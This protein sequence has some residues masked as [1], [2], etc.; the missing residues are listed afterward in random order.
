MIYG[1][2]GAWR[3]Q[4]E[5]LGQRERAVAARRADYNGYCVLGD[6]GAPTLAMVTPPVAIQKGTRVLISRWD[7]VRAGTRYPPEGW[8]RSVGHTARSLNDIRG[9][10]LPM[11]VVDA[12]HGA[13]RPIPHRVFSW[14]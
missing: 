13:T 12:G 7:Y 6:G 3:T 10:R 9:G 4:A 2:W 5:R 8:A 1:G 11:L 14:Q